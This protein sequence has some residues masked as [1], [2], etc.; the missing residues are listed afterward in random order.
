MTAVGSRRKDRPGLL[1][2]CR[3]DVAAMAEV[4]GADPS[5]VVGLA[6]VLMLPGTWAVILFRVAQALHRRGLRPLSRLVYFV[7][8]VLFSVDLAPSADVGPGLTLPH[9]FGVA[10]GGGLEVDGVLT[11]VRIGRKARLMGGVRIGGGGFEDRSRDGLPE[12][13]DDVWMMDGAKVFG[14]V[15]IGDRTVV[16]VSSIV[17]QDLPDGVVAIGTPARVM[18]RRDPDGDGTDVV[19]APPPP[20]DAS[21]VNGARS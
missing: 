14:R 6:D 16:A 9:P 13:G 19:D 15:R 3:A 7:N 17:T 2:T 1:A 18:K 5:S 11:E 10:I 4:K 21:S 20:V 8:A 12:L